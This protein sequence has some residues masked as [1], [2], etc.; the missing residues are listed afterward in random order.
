MLFLLSCLLPSWGRSLV[1]VSW[2]EITP[3]EPCSAWCAQDVS[4]HWVTP[5]F[6]ALCGKGTVSCKGHTEQIACMFI[7]AQQS[8]V[9]GGSCVSA[10]KVQNQGCS[11]LSREGEGVGKEDSNPDSLNSRCPHLLVNVGPSQFD[12]IPFNTLSELGSPHLCLIT[13]GSPK[14]T[15]IVGH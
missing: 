13:Q 3:A 10:G 7:T 1:K 14:A 9:Q 6:S 11:T 4:T 5:M 12:S 15:L 8:S 2:P